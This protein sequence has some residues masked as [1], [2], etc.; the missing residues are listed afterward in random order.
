MDVK[1]LVTEL[2]KVINNLQKVHIEATEE[3][4]AYM[5]GSISRLAGIR[6]GLI[7]MA[8]QASPV[9][10]ELQN[11]APAEVNQNGTEQ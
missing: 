1:A 11:E 5:Y 9:P 8:K 4:L 2:Q 7:D 6:D 3:N 10:E